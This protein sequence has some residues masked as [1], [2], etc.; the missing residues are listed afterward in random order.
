MSVKK[1]KSP[2][3]IQGTFFITGNPKQAAANTK[4]ILN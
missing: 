3:K 2:L 4:F 1:T